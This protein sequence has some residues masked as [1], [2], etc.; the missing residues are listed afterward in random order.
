MVVGHVLLALDYDIVHK[1]GMAWVVT[2]FRSI[3]SSCDWASHH[4]WTRGTL[5]LHVNKSKSTTTRTDQ[6]HGKF[7]EYFN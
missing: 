2:K 4:F 3:S 7:V 5:E 6:F 1:K